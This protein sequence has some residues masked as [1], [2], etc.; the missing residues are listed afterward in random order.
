MRLYLVAKQQQN[1]IVKYVYPSEK[2]RSWD[3]LP[4]DVWIYTGQGIQTANTITKAIF[5]HINA[6]FS[7][8]GYKVHEVNEKNIKEFLKEDVLK[9]WANIIGR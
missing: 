1:G 4:Q 9:S 2:E 8:K 5:L 7:T 6:S 3:E